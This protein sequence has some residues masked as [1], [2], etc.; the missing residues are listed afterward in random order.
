MTI[1]YRRF[2]KVSAVRHYRTE[3]RPPALWNECVTMVWPV[4]GSAALVIFH[5]SSMSKVCP[6]PLGAGREIFIGKLFVRFI[7]FLPRR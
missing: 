2:M 4:Y 5:L 3:R 6:V 7:N 1:R